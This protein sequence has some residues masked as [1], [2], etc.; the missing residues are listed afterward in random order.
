MHLK[1]IYALISIFALPVMLF[2]A[3]SELKRPNVIVLMTDQERHPMHWPDGWVEAH[4]PSMARL[5]KH[6][7][8]FE[9]AY[10]ASSMCSPSRATLLTS[11]F[12]TVTHVP[13]TLADASPSPTLPSKDVL[14]NLA[15][16]VQKKTHY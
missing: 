3:E 12:S 16:L 9:R 6:G 11:Q 10:T 7:L 15:S 1:R 2:S 5:K 14:T 4:L 13:L 8:T